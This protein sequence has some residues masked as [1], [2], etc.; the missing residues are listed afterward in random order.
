[1]TLPLVARV[2]HAYSFPDLPSL[3]ASVL[4][5]ACRAVALLF[6]PR[7]FLLVFSFFYLSSYITAVVAIVSLAGALTFVVAPWCTTPQQ[8]DVVIGFAVCSNVHALVAMLIIDGPLLWGPLV[9]SFAAILTL[10][11]RLYSKSGQ[12]RR[13]Q[14]FLVVY[15]WVL[16][17]TVLLLRHFGFV[18]S[19]DLIDHGFT[20]NVRIVVNSSYFNFAITN[21]WL[22]SRG[23]VNDET[24][25]AQD[26][27]FA[28]ISHD[29]RQPCH[30]MSLLIPFITEAMAAAEAEGVTESDRHRLL[31]NQKADM[32]QLKELVDT[33]LALVGDFLFFSKLR[34]QGPGLVP[35]A[36][37]TAFRPCELVE[38]VGSVS[39]LLAS[40]KCLDVKM[41]CIDLDKTVLIGPV[42][43]L[44]RILGNLVHTRTHTHDSTILHFHEFFF[45]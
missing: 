13:F 34:Q 16:F 11:A 2:K 20:D 6:L 10:I 8:V 22:I 30:A 1:M 25:R 5:A 32:H 31:N 43:N 45:F 3:D 19:S 17:N 23:V 12:N 24:V 36:E 29:M 40:E 15:V 38:E 4:W 42:K 35:P 26:R 14:L 27:L 18:I 9:A 41:P 39:A 33:L 44:K 37:S 21:A 28:S 7:L